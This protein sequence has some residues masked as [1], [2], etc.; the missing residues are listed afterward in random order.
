[1]RL[2]PTQVDG[3]LTL[4]LEAELSNNIVMLYIWIRRRI[5]MFHLWA[6]S[7]N[8]SCQPSSPP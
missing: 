6:L 1:M 8:I 7:L 3:R 5:D 2:L 4:E